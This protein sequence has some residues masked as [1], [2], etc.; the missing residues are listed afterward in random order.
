MTPIESGDAAS[1]RSVVRRTKLVLEAFTTQPRWGVRE[2]ASRLGI[3]KSGLHRTLQ[4]MSVEG[5]LRSDEDGSYEVGAE[6]L[7][8][9]AQHL[10][11]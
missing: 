1:S 10:V 9:I 6:L 11:G 3:A 2:L 4:E 5:L 8:K 7:R